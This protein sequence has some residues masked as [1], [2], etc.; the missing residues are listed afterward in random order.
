MVIDLEHQANKAHRVFMVEDGLLVGQNSPSGPAIEVTN[1][2][3]VL[4]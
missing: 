4:T 2:L 3:V 1:Q